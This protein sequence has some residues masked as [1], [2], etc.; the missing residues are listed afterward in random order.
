MRAAK[1]RAVASVNDKHA[2]IKAGDFVFGSYI[3]S[4]CDAPCIIF[5]DGEQIEVDK[6]T[7]SQYIDVDDFNGREIYSGDIIKK[8]NG[9]WGVIVWKAPSFEVT[10][11]E[12]QSSLYSLAYFEDDEVIGDIYRDPDFKN[13]LGEKAL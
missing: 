10:V 7:L 9:D 6:K 5:G 11:S 13:S 8:P 1:F 2:G 3:E 4:G 12:T